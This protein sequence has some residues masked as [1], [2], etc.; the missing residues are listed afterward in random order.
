MVFIDIKI[1]T[2]VINFE[3]FHLTE[4]IPATFGDENGVLVVSVDLRNR[5]VASLFVGFDVNIEVLVLD[6]H[7]TNVCIFK[8]FQTF[9]FIPAMVLVNFSKMASPP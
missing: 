2:Y 8:S 5:H 1:E 4:F 3:P 9:G 6:P 7:T